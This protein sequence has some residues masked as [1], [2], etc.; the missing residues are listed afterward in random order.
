ME[1]QIGGM[2]LQIPAGCGG[3]GNSKMEIRNYQPVGDTCK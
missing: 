1:I 2:K 3:I